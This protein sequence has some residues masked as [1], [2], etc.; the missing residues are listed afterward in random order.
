[1]RRPIG[2]VH[3]F[4]GQLHRWEVHLVVRLDQI[5]IR[6]VYDDR[7]RV[8]VLVWIGAVTG[9][10]CYLAIGIKKALKLDDS[11]DVIA[12]HLIGG[13]LGSL[14]LLP[15]QAAP[16]ADVR[17]EI[18]RKLNIRVEDVRPAPFPGMFEVSNGAEIAY[19][20]ADGRY[21]L[22]GDLYD[23]DSKENLTDRRRASAREPGT[24][25]LRRR[26]TPRVDRMG[27]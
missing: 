26:R 23:M 16:P 19:V 14:L 5:C 9:V 12:V 22:D 18:A 11:L 17:A 20:S 8:D 10:V 2:D 27:S 6:A 25:E 24:V 21:Y 1:M 7:E 3:R 4:D 15:V 13:L